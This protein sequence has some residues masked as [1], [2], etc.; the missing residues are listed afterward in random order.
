ML[1][2]VEVLGM[3]GDVISTN[4]IFQYNPETKRHGF[5]GA[6]PRTISEKCIKSG[7]V[8]PDSLWS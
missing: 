2:M 4:P 8:L 6:P 7:I 5:S 3:E 1:E